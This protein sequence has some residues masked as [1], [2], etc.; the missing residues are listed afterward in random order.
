MKQRVIIV[1]LL[2]LFSVPIFATELEGCSFYSRVLQ[3]EINY[4]VVLPD[5]YSTTKQRYPVLYMLHGLGDNASSWLE[6]GSVAQ[7]SK[8][9]VRTGEIQPMILI[10]PQGFSDYYSNF[11]SG[12]YN[13][14]T[15]F[16]T[17]LVP[18][19]D[20]LYRT[21]ANAQN[22]AV[23]GY[24]MGGFGALMLPINHPDLFSVSIP[25]S[26]SIRTHEQYMTEQ[27]QTGWD[28]QWG[29]I[30]GGVG[31]SGEARLT[32][33]Y[34][35][36]SPFA[37]I[38]SKSSEELNRVQ[39]FI[40]NGDQEGTLCR[41][42]EELHQLLL[43]KGVAHVYRVHSG[44][45][46]FNFWRSALPAVFRFA[47]AQFHNKPFDLSATNELPKIN[48][49]Q[50]VFCKTYR[51]LDHEL[52]LYYPFED[53]YSQRKYAVVYVVGCPDKNTEK[54]IAQYY[55]A[56][57]EKGLLPAMA[58][59]FVPQALASHLISDIAPM[60]E[61]Q[62]NARDNRRYRSV[63]Q[64]SGS[65]DVV[66]AQTLVPQLFTAAV[67]TNCQFGDKATLETL[68]ASNEATKTN[69]QLFIYSPSMAGSTYSGNGYLHVSLREHGF[70]HQYRA[71]PFEIDPLA[72][73]PDLFLFI[74]ERIHH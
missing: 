23:T 16:V 41:S 19:I 56:S 13:Y 39:F 10:M 11:Y 43:D 38:A 42:N 63:W 61:S 49:R 6:Y 2:G 4:S 7:Q 40:D 46:D 64:M 17:E 69:L 35:K 30:F 68:V 22:R 44:G 59:C 29:R 48:K 14:Q 60:L 25:L 73:M 37:V 71:M 50:S 70:K 55:T 15:M 74:S 52:P 9:M 3:K 57:Y 34:L 20:S 18:L 67:F 8:Q 72:I 27:S 26:A 51:C 32:D 66:L 12:D 33:Y 28:Q 53:N 1:F 5:N 31:L 62:A 58:L 45:H 24:S 21:I 54:R 36:N 65:A 47:D